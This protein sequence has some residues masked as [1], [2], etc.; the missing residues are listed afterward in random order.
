MMEKKRKPLPEL[1]ATTE[2]KR[3]KGWLYFTGT[4]D[5]G[6]ITILRL[7]AGRRKVGE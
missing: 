4:D 1:L 6:N 2:I 3:E 5:K 7:K